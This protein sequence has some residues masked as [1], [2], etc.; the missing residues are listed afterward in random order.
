[1]VPL[2]VISE[3]GREWGEATARELLVV[4]QA[5]N[6]DA[7]QNEIVSTDGMGYENWEDSCLGK[8]SEFLG[9]S[10]AGYETEMLGLMWKMVSQQQRDQRKGKQTETKCVRKLRKLECTINYNSQS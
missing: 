4:D 5:N 10:M 9:I 1:M 8:F 6:V 2:R 7:L 3:D